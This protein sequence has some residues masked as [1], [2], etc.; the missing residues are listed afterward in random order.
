MTRTARHLP[1]LALAL[2]LTS[3]AVAQQ[4]VPPSVLQEI[5]RALSRVPEAHRPAMPGRPG[6]GQAATPDVDRFLRSAGATASRRVSVGFVNKAPHKALVIQFAP[7]GSGS[8]GENRLRRETL[9]PRAIMSWP[10]N[11]TECRYDVRITFA[12]GNEF[13]RLD[14]DFC[15]QDKL[16]VT[17]ADPAA[18]PLPARERVALFRVVNRSSEKVAVLRV[19]P[20]GAA[21]PQPDLLGI[22]MMEPGDSYTGRVARG[23]NCLYD[24]RVG[25]DPEDTQNVTLARQNLCETSEIVIPARRASGG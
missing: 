16:E 4:G 22:W 2:A 10:I 3:P 18:A 14:H 19:T 25:F 15:A 7:V 12:L 24:V 13:V 11:S 6:A 21:R 8:W 23:G 9:N 17:S 20:A 1:L 5:D